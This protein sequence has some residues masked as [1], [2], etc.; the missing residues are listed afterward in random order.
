MASSQTSLNEHFK[1]MNNAILNRPPT[2]AEVD[3]FEF[4]AWL[5]REAKKAEVYEQ[6]LIQ[7]ITESG[8]PDACCERWSIVH[9]AIK[10]TGIQLPAS[11]PAL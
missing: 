5:V 1:T 3:N 8:C 9:H 6:A 4:M 10:A 2:Q 11:V 7:I